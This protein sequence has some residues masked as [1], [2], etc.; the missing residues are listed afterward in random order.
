MSDSLGLGVTW[1]E[2]MWDVII[3]FLTR[4][5]SVV[6]VNVGRYHYMSDSLGL[7]VTRYESMWDVIIAFPTRRV[8]V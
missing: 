5:E 4:C 2:S 1:C 7:G 8:S 6:R 3:T